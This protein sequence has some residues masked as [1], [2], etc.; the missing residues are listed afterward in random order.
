MSPHEHPKSLLYLIVELFFKSKF[1]N[2]EEDRKY[3]I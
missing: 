2:I 1:T 3:K